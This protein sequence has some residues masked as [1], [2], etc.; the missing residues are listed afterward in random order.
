MKKNLIISLCLILII[1]S[2]CNRRVQNFTPVNELANEEYN[3]ALK[4]V[5]EFSS[6]ENPPISKSK[7]NEIQIK[8]VEKKQI[9]C[10]KQ[11]KLNRSNDNESYNFDLYIFTLIK[12]GKTGFA[13]VTGDKR[14][15]QVA[16]YVEYGAL[17]DTSSIPEMAFVVRNLE[18]GLR[19]D[20]LSYYNDIENIKTR[21]NEPYDKVEINPLVKTKWDVS[22]PYNNYYDFG[23]CST[24][25]QRYKVSSTA[26]AFAQAIVTNKKRPDAFPFNYDLKKWTQ[27]PQINISDSY[28]PQVAEFIYSLEGGTHLGCT[29]S[30]CDLLLA[31]GNTTYYGY[32]EGNSYIYENTA[33]KYH[34]IV[35]NL[36][37]G[38]C[39]IIGGKPLNS[40][41]G[42]I[43]G[44]YYCWIIDGFKGL[45]NKS[46]TNARLAQV[47][48]TYG[49]GG[50]GNGWYRNPFNEHATGDKR[51][52]QVNLQF[53]YFTP[54]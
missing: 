45:I 29:K 24:P 16:A 34:Y 3:T 12:D 30:Y 41:T 48:C 40:V 28:A 13:I 20:L 46:G 49:Y 8:C 6:Q 36:R 25:N 44:E 51:P 22:S 32:T 33:I 37:Q 42:G 10:S 15:A 52:I 43:P 39:T 14:I 53:L 54:F 1:F 19:N 17:A 2:N 35:N 26:L 21:T 23:N 27:K 18:N 50:R 31:K 7:N 47:H 11:I 4:L 5:E 38:Y 9:S